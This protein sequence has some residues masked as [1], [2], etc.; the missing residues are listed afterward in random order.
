MLEDYIKT[1][2]DNVEAREKLK[3][4]LLRNQ[5]SIPLLEQRIRLQEKLERQEIEEESAGIEI[6][7]VNG[8]PQGDFIRM[9][10]DHWEKRSDTPWSGQWKG[11]AETEL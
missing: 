4:E 11:A 5:R 9:A 3:K 8:I 10:E 1:V 7:Y 6:E 2:G